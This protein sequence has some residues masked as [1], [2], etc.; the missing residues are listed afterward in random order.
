M[1]NDTPVMQAVQLHRHYSARR[2]LFGA[3]LPVRAL[4]GVSF[5]LA[6]GRTLAVVG[7]SG[8]GKS[9]L[10]R[11]LTMV[12][13]P[14]SGQ[15]LIDGADVASGDATTRRRL[16]PQ[17]QIVFQNPYGSL[18]PRHTVGAAL[19][20]PLAAQGLGGAEERALAAREMLRKVGLREEHFSRYPHMFSGGQRQ[21]IAIARALM[22]KPRVL[23]LDEP[24]SALDVSI[25]AQVLNLLADLQAELAVAYVFISHDL[26]VV[27]HVADDVMVMYLGC[28]VEH[29]ARDAI[30]DAPQHPYTRA[31]LSA[32]PTVDVASRRERIVLR[33]EL[34]S[35]LNPPAGCA[36]HTRCPIA[37][38]MCR[39]QVPVLAPHAGR[40]AACHALSVTEGTASLV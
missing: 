12:E 19:Q 30:F 15:L 33:G 21:R 40:Q 4:N 10:A 11:V 3:A 25:R 1:S 17:V 32:T 36:F 7:E 29:G 18:N 26:S 6:A 2:G 37:M 24:V 35:P 20:E 23:V 34:P 28:V 27:R 38:P 9:T 16:R 31:L 22:L 13:P 39:Q 5:T 8:C 14:T